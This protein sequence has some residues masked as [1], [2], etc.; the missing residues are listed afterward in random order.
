MTG[1]PDGQLLLRIYALHLQ[2][3]AVDCA[4]LDLAVGASQK[5]LK[6]NAG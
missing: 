4:A 2:L 3:C 1:R 6:G 5:A